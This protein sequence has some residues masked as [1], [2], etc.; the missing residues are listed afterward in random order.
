MGECRV[1]GSPAYFLGA[2][3]AP[4]G[5]HPH[6]PP[7]RRGR[8]SKG[9]LPTCG[10]RG[11]GISPSPGQGTGEGGVGAGA[12]VRA[13]GVEAQAVVLP[14]LLGF[15]R[16]FSGG[17]GPRFA[18]PGGGGGGEGVGF[19]WFLGFVLH[20]L[21]VL[22]PWVRSARAPGGRGLSGSPGYFLKAP[23]AAGFVL[24]PLR[25]VRACGF[26]VGFARAFFVVGC[27]RASPAAATG[28]DGGAARRFG[29]RLGRWTGMERSDGRLREV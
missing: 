10:G 24:F 26:M 21:R 2:S 8:G 1:S 27:A 18:L 6:P 14:G 5:P 22:Q 20:F 15:A 11:G 19:V 28:G 13:P 16:Q 17:D 4:Y 25:R 3:P 12:A 7:L 23:G 9:G 29:G